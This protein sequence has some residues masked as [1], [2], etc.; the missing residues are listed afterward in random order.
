MS[1]G[2]DHERLGALDLPFAADPI[3][4]DP[5]RLRALAD[6][7]PDNGVLSIYVDADPR[8]QAHSVPPWKVL[9][10]HELR[11]I[12]EGLRTNGPR[13]RWTAFTRMLDS[14]A[15][16][17]GAL[18]DV[19]T[20]GRGRALLIPLDG[21]PARALAIQAPMTTA[22]F[23]EDTPRLL[24]LVAALDRGALIG[25][26]LATKHEIRIL[27]TRF[28]RIG[29]VE[30]RRFSEV[31]EAS[32]RRG[33]AAANPVRGQQ[34]VTHTEKHERHLEARRAAF[35]GS[36]MAEVDTRRVDAGWEGILI[37]GP[38]GL[39]EELAGALPNADVHVAHYDIGDVS[40]DALL[41]ELGPKIEAF[42]QERELRAL[43]AARESAAAS[44]H[45]VIGLERTLEALNEGRVAHLF[46]PGELDVPG[47][48]LP[49][50][51]LAPADS[52]AGEPI[53]SL[54]EAMAIRALDASARVSVAESKAT[55]EPLAA[56]RW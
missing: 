30:T 8:Q 31:S 46:L 17:R 44:G 20:P 26:V 41:D 53:S 5:S 32:E 48:V 6:W 51:R 54:F 55:T 12:Q 56:T 13:E 49:D 33:P 21:G 9:I 7:R 47:C 25:V 4:L 38:P 36:V 50:G 2:N 24:P 45:G 18:M 3:P 27:D 22:A 14:T 28:H 19:S 34:T 29:N 15:E 1:S 37:V 40:I 52:G 23:L 11:A 16:A 39:A 43:G 10:E 42:A 35:T